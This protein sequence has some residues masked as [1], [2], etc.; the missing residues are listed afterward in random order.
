M[1]STT[2]VLD[3]HSAATSQGHRLTETL[4]VPVGLDLG[5][6]G[7]TRVVRVVV[8]RDSYAPQSYARAQLLTTDGVWTTIA[9]AEPSTWHAETWVTV[10]GANQL[11]LT[12]AAAV[13]R[14][15]AGVADQLAARAVKILASY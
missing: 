2:V 1:I 14:A 10:P 9:E 7:D 15:L 13:E 6:V 5:R 8:H 3:R 12:M 4:R 11:G